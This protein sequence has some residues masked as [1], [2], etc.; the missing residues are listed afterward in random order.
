MA[1]KILL[2]TGGR[3]ERNNKRNLKITTESDGLQGEHRITADASVTSM[4][5]LKITI[6]IIEDGRPLETVQPILLF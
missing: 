1:A 3:G 4:K 6:R 5:R 2:K